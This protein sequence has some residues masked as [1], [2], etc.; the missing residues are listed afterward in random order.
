MTE[1]CQTWDDVVE[2][3]ILAVKFD[4]DVTPDM[5]TTM[6]DMDSDDDDTLLDGD[7]HGYVSIEKTYIEEEPIWR[8]L[9]YVRKEPGNDD[10]WAE[11]PDDL[12]SIRERMDGWKTPGARMTLLDFRVD[13]PRSFRDC[14]YMPA[15]CDSCYDQEPHDSCENDLNEHFVDEDGQCVYCRRGKEYRRRSKRI[16]ARMKENVA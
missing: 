4:Q 13:A 3:G 12:E 6:W 15:S 10:P 8:G 9:L 1:Q 5:Q 11:Q 16:L 2:K 14:C 7:M